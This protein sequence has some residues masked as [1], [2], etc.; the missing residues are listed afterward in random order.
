MKQ[1]ITGVDVKIDVRFDNGIHA[2]VRRGYGLEIGEYTYKYYWCHKE[3]NKMK[4]MKRAH[5]LQGLLL[6]R[7]LNEKA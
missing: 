3:G 2:V 1:V 5:L 6:Q 4:F 7:S